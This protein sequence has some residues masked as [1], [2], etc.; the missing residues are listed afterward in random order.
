MSYCRFGNDS[1]VYMIDT[2]DYFECVCCRML[3]KF[4]GMHKSRIMQNTMSA[5]KHL[6]A[7]RTHGHRVPRYAIKRLWGEITGRLNQ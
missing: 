3:P 7:H 6:G 2:G 1:D 4:G 5:L